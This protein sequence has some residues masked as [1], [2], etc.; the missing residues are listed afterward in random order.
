MGY[1]SVFSE[2]LT[3]FRSGKILKISGHGRCL[4]VSCAFH[5]AFSPYIREFVTIIR[6]FDLYL[7]APPQISTD[8][9]YNPEDPIDVP[10][11]PTLASLEKYGRL[12]KRLCIHYDESRFFVPDGEYGHWSKD[13]DKPNRPLCGLAQ[14]KICATILAFCSALKALELNGIDCSKRYRPYSGG[15]G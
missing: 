12:I 11:G 2:Y 4:R 10:Q 7:D 1:A 14:E 9:D 8:K 5:Q 3:T 15:C 13:R 6:P